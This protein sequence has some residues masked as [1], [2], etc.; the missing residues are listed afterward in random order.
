MLAPGGQKL[1]N[2]GLFEGVWIVGQ[3]RP[4]FM[5]AIRWN[6]YYDEFINSSS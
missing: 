2:V 5:V 4:L 1:A 3:M 6:R